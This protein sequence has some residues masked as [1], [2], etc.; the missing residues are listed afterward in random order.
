MALD[1]A[2]FGGGGEQN[3]GTVERW[4]SIAGGAALV[5]NGL[6]RPSLMNTVLALGGAALVQRG[7]TGSC[8]L[9]RQLGISTA[10]ASD[11][12][13]GDADQMQHTYG[14]GKRGRQSIADEI[15]AA[16]E[17]SFPA[18]DPPPWT[19]QTAVGSPEARRG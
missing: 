1:I 9:Y 8:P 17:E 15:E 6:M 7:V 2:G 10:T 5:V 3:V 4:V 16:S 18:S 12:H 13:R 11:G 14:Y 19:P